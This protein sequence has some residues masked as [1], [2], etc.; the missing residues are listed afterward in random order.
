MDDVQESNSYGS[1]TINESQAASILNKAYAQ[2][3]GSSFMDD[4]DKKTASPYFSGLA[5]GIPVIGLFC[6]DTTKAEAFAKLDGDKASFKD[7][8]KEYLG[9]ATTGA[10]T[11]AAVGLCSFVPFG[12]IAGAAIGAGVSVVQTLLKDLF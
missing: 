6:N 5:Q 9:A 11:G 4:L 8:V 3:T 2:A 12:P 7:K 1:Y 10:A